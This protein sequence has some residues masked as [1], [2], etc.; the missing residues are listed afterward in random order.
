MLQFN[1]NAINI[2]TDQLGPIQ[3]YFSPSHLAL[4]S[5]RKKNLIG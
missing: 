2:A 3:P 4:S 5:K 1:L